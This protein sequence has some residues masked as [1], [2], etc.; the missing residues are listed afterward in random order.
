[1]AP[2]KRLKTDL[3]IE[4]G[5]SNDASVESPSEVEPKRKIAKRNNSVESKVEPSS[6]SSS[7]PQV[8]TANDADEKEA[9]QNKPEAENPQTNM[10]DMNDHALFEMMD[11]M[12]LPEL[13]T[14]AE[15]S[16]HLKETAQEVLFHPHFSLSPML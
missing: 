3:P 13:C 15:V 11:R 12:G 7:P 9:T 14:M 1:M 5:S 8:A 10:L 16:V 4:S 6:S 2:A